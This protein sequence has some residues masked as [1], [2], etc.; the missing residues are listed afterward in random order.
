MFVCPGILQHVLS[1][2]IIRIGKGKSCCR[3]QIKKGF[4]NFQV[5]AEFTMV[6]QVIMSDIGEYASCK[7]ESR[8]TLLINGM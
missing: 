5:F 3:Q 2:L 6:I 8:N 7:F 1:V 4:F